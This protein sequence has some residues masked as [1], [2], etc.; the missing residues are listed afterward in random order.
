[1]AIKFNEQAQA[2]IIFGKAKP[3]AVDFVTLDGKTHRWVFTG[4]GQFLL[5]EYQRYA[6][7]LVPFSDDLQKAGDDAESISKV[8]KELRPAMKRF[9]RAWKANVKSDDGSSDEW[10]DQNL[11]NFTYSTAVLTNLMKAVQNADNDK[12]ESE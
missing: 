12:G 1:M 7:E 11:S 2:D 3:V 5:T 4:G 10:I 9:T 6:L 8:I